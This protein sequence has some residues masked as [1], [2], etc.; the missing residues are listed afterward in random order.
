MGRNGVTT[1]N[2]LSKAEVL[3]TKRKLLI[4]EL[5]YEVC[6]PCAHVLPDDCKKQNCPLCKQA[7][8]DVLGAIKMFGI[9]SH[10]TNGNEAGYFIPESWLKK[11]D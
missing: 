4:I 11:V 8:E 3:E 6:T 7:V 1:Q 5:K 9:K 2:K 10:P